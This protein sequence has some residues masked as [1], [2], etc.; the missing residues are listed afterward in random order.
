MVAHIETAAFLGYGAVSV[1]V[2]A[3]LAPGHSA[4]TVSACPIKLWPQATNVC[5]AQLGRQNCL[6]ED[7][8][9]EELD[10]LAAPD[11]AGQ[12]LLD[13]IAETKKTECTGFNRILRVGRKLADLD[14]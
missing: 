1:D 2:R 14:H 12:N 10:K 5:A 11:S 3:H 13:R 6:N 7:L 9:G 8:E 4:F